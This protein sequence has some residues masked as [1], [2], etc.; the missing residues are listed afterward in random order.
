MSTVAPTPLAKAVTVHARVFA[1]LAGRWF[2]Q[3]SHGDGV[4]RSAVVRTRGV[5]VLAANGYLADRIEG[6]LQRAGLIGPVQ[7]DEA[8]QEPVSGG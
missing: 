5:L 7:I 8:H 3:R 6:E 1:D 2:Q 4:D